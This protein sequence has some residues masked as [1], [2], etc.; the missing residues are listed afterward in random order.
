MDE[1]G[2]IAQP[3]DPKFSGTIPQF[4]GTPKEP[5]GTTRK[6]EIGIYFKSIRQSESGDEKLRSC[7][8]NSVMK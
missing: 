1:A 8:K 5:T 4:S 6:Q 7:G 3:N 2:V